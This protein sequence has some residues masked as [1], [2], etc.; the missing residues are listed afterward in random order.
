MIWIGRDLRRHQFQLSCYGQGHLPHEHVALSPIPSSAN[1]HLV[2][3]MLCSSF[4][5]FSIRCT[6]CAFLKASSVSGCM[7]HDLCPTSLG[8]VL[9]TWEIADEQPDQWSRRSWNRSLLWEV[10]NLTKTHQRRLEALWAKKAGLPAAS[11]LL[12]CTGIYGK[13]KLQYT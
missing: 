3:H 13:W 7:Y 4:G 8:G 6:E 1:G 5:T 11:P 9:S 10:G 2:Q 12:S